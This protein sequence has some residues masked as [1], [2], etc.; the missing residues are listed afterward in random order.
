MYR[1][2]SRFAVYLFIGLFVYLFIGLLP[3]HAAGWGG[4]VENGDVATIQCLA[5]MFERVV[6][7]IL[8]LSGVALFVMLVI[9]GYNFLLS[10]GDQ[11]KLEMAKGTI[12]G[13]LLGLVI[14]VIAFLIIKT[15]ATFTG[16]TTV[17]EFNIP[18]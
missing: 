8:A 9:G 18:K 10:G 4:C 6:Q 5:P 7:G 11:K 17:T 1:T 16:V 13:A 2:F 14:M 15:V 3:A 12:T